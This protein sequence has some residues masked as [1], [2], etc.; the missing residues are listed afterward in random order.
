MI[1]IAREELVAARAEMLDGM[2]NYI[3][4]RIGDEEIFNIWFM[5]GVPDGAT[6]DDLLEIAKDDELWTDCIECFAKCCRV[7][8]VI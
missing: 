1:N 3:L 7:A 2:N 5:G 4:E 8:G 6:M